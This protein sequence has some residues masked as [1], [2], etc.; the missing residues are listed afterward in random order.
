MSLEG[1]RPDQ[2]G[3]LNTSS[4]RTTDCTKPTHRLIPCFLHSVVWYELST[5]W[6]PLFLNFTFRNASWDSVFMEYDDGET[7]AMTVSFVYSDCH[8]PS[9]FRHV[10][11]ILALSAKSRDFTIQEWT[12]CFLTSPPLTVQ[13]R[14]PHLIVSPTT[15]QIRPHLIR[16]FLHNLRTT[17]I[18]PYDLVILVADTRPWL[19]QEL[20]LTQFLWLHYCGWH[21]YSRHLRFP[22]RHLISNKKH[23]IFSVTS[24]SSDI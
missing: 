16:H 13:S 20:W 19:K 14:W 3:L 10:P 12:N 9:R 21:K 6:L 5:I 2:T 4:G 17:Q 23:F 24:A 1:Q 8:I 11:N 15:K 18:S 7:S 22:Q